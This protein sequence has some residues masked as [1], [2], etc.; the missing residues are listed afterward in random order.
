MLKRRYWKKW[1]RDGFIA[2]VEIDQL[3]KKDTIIAELK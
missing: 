3:K 1:L 2:L